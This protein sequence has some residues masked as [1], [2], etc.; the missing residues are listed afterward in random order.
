MAS[1]LLQRKKEFP[2]PSPSTQRSTKGLG[3]AAS[4]QRVLGVP[5]LPATET[6]RY[7]LTGDSNLSQMHLELRVNWGACL[8]GVE[9][10]CPHSF[11]IWL[12]PFAL[13]FDW[14]VWAG[15]EPH[16]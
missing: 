15:V 16:G 11:Y 12:G 6:V 13:A 4:A 5:A 2:E 10:A 9:F 1:G 14:H 8:I 3:T 7:A